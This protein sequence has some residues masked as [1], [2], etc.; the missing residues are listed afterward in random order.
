[1]LT[2]QREGQGRVTFPDLLNTDP[3]LQGKCLLGLKGRNISGICSL[4]ITSLEAE[5]GMQLNYILVG[6]RGYPQSVV[7]Q[8]GSDVEALAAA[9]KKSSEL[10][11]PSQVQ[12]FLAKQ[13]NGDWMSV[14]AVVVDALTSGDEDAIARVCVSALAPSAELL[15][16]F[17]PIALGHRK[18]HL[19]VR[20]NEPMSTDGRGSEEELDLQCLVVGDRLGSTFSMKMK[21]SD[22]IQDLRL[23]VKKLKFDH[24]LEI[25]VDGLCVYRAQVTYKFGFFNLAYRNG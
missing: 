14:D 21:K 24:N 23:R 11:K 19:V 4:I 18:L 16:H 8:P 1:M 15:Q 13:D 20:E 5:V 22:L 7:V 25:R 17:T 2:A 9:I 12:I 3:K 6:D 10:T